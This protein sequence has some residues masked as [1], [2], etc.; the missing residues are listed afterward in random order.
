VRGAGEPP[1]P[2]ADGACVRLLSLQ[3]GRADLVG[4][5]RRLCE[6]VVA[7]EADASALDEAALDAEVTA[8][9]G[10]PEPSLVLQCCPQLHL[11]GLLPWHCRVTQFA[12]LGPLRAATRAAVHRA[13]DAHDRVVQRHGR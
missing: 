3:T 11:G 10:F 12:H 6:R 13:F 8:N 2:A 5:A 4:A 1:P 9:L 7:G